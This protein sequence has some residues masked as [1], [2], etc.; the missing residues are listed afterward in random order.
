MFSKKPKSAP[1]IPNANHQVL[2]RFPFTKYPIA[3]P[4]AKIPTAGIIKAIRG[5]PER[6]I[7]VGPSA[8]PIIATEDASFLLFISSGISVN[9]S[10][11]RFIFRTLSVNILSI[12]LFY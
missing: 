5:S 9:S 10:P 6:Y 7:A 12:Y 4:T 2:F 8:P 11:I 1:E 3:K